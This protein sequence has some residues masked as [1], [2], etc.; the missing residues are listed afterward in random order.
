MALSFL[1]YDD[2]FYDLL[3]YEEISKEEYEKRKAAMRPF[4]PSL[5]TKYE[6]EEMEL[7]IGSS[8]CVGGVCPIR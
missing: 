5:L 3:P 4:N 6:F 7:D 1:S 2:N 8:E